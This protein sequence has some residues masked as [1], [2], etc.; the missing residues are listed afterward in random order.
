MRSMAE[1]D[2]RLEEL[3]AT[4]PSPDKLP[5]FKMYPIDFEKPYCFEYLLHAKHWSDSAYENAQKR[6]DI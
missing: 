1:Y 3:K 5:G 2:S 6:W 4:L